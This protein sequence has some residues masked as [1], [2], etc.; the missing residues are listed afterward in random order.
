MPA[1]ALRNYV[2]IPSGI[3]SSGVD[4]ELRGLI[5]KSIVPGSTRLHFNP[6]AKSINGDNDEDAEDFQY[7]MAV[8]VDHRLNDYWV[9]IA[10]YI[11]S[12]A[13]S[14]G[15]NA[16][17]HEAEFGLDWKLADHQKL[18]FAFLVGLDGD[19]DGPAFGAEVSY[20]FSFGG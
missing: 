5:T 13:E 12:S 9:L 7:G 19:D 8:G 10:D 20:M 16:A 2:R 18:G 3:G 1:F 14:E 4:Y 11:Y 6:F 17:N 15:D